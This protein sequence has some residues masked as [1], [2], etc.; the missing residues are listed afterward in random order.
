MF[1]S[2]EHRSERNERVRSNAAVLVVTGYVIWQG[3][4]RQVIAIKKTTNGLS[5]AKKELLRSLT[6]EQSG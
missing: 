6:C 4:E 5:T 2:A 1:A 3:A